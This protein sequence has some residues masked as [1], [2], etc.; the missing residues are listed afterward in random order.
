VCYGETHA[1]RIAGTGRVTLQ[2]SSGHF[3][4][5]DRLRASYLLQ[6]RWKA[7]EGQEKG[8]KGYNKSSR[9]REEYGIGNNGIRMLGKRG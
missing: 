8:I 7:G 3:I 4:T 2:A 1:A 5:S 9:R 6:R